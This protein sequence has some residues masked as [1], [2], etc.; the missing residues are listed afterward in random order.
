M[1][2]VL[3]AILVLLF[4]LLGMAGVQVRTT[5]AEFESYQRTQ[6][7]VLL[8]D[9]VD[10]IQANRLMADCY[11]LT[12]ASTGA[13]FAGT[14]AT[15]PAACGTGTAPNELTAQTDLSDWSNALMG[16]AEVQAGV[17]IGAMI[18]ARGCVTADGSGAYTVT[19][20]WQGMSATAAP[21]T[22]LTCGTGLY[23]TE[24]LRRV[25]SAKVQAA[26][27]TPGP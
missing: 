27:L 26:T 11:S 19:V 7:L 10:R 23:G 15:L 24:T 2:E 25:V 4:G 13:P 6:A 1:L 12:T 20:A 14:G 8:H 18:G 21:P 16:A 9:I 22:A 3:I 17:N 5:Q